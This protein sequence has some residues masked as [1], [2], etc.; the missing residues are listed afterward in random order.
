[1]EIRKEL[2]VCHAPP[3]KVSMFS[4]RSLKIIIIIKDLNLPE[5]HSF[6]LVSIIQFQFPADFLSQLH[7]LIN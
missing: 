1:M 7:N 4:A 3:L 6:K 5:G 2:A